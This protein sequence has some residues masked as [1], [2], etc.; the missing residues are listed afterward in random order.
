MEKQEK[1]KFKFPTEQIELPSKGLLYPEG[2]PLSSGTIEMKYMTARE[3][4]ILTNLNYVK[5]GIVIDKLL[6]SLIVTE[7]DYSDLLTGDKNAIMVAARVLGY[8]KDYPFTYKGEEIIVDLS[9]LLPVEL[10]EKSITKGVNEFEYELPFSKNKIT[11]KLLNGKDE[12]AIE[13]EMK[14]LKRINK[15]S[16]TDIS[17]R[18]KHQI[19]SID[20]NDDKKSVRE[21]VD[22]YMLAR[23]SSSF[24][25]HLKL[26]QPDIKMTFNHDGVDGDE[27]VSVPIEVQFFWPDS[28]I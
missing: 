10:D 3:E 8:G 4:D 17:T 26:T 19:I 15:N 23:D 11:Y 28:R 18:L 27:E 14:G 16:S 7:F 12:K 21:F 25:Q 1:P 20:G 24:R 13:A 22:G 2:H 5:Q 6:Q 9:E